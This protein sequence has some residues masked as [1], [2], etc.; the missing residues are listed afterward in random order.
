MKKIFFMVIAFVVLCSQNAFTV[1]NEALY[2]IGA[3][4]IV[5]HDNW[6]TFIRP[7]G[8]KNVIKMGG[9]SQ[10]PEVNFVFDFIE[11]S[12]GEFNFGVSID[13]PN[14]KVSTY[15]FTQEGFLYIDAYK[16]NV[17]YSVHVYNGC[18]LFDIHTSERVKSSII[19][20]ATKHKYITTEIYM[21][22]DNRPLLFQFSLQGF[23]SAYER[24]CY[25]L[26]K[27]NEKSKEKKRL[28][29]YKGTVDSLMMQ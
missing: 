7:V 13:D 15:T 8:N 19:N 28:E 11:D 2:S 1:T 3:K 18:T 6:I 14:A 27:K 24:V 17:K 9:H 21:P 22:F 26:N 4:D 10:Y 16:Y 25:L 5:R 29:T 20:V 23:S 12:M